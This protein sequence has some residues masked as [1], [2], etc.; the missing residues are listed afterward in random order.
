MVECASK[1]KNEHT[2][3]ILSPSKNI[4]ATIIPECVSKK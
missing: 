1:K 3:N 4:Y 2:S